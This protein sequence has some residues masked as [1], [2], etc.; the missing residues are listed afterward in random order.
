M[1]LKHPSIVLKSHCNVWFYCRFINVCVRV[2]DGLYRYVKRRGAVFV[3]IQNRMSEG[4]G[5]F[6]LVSHPDTAQPSYHMQ[7]GVQRSNKDKL[8]IKGLIKCKDTE[9]E[10]RTK[11]DF[12]IWNWIANII[13]YVFNGV[14]DGCFSMEWKKKC[15][16]S[17]TLPSSYS[18]VALINQ[19]LT[20]QVNAFNNSCILQPSS[21]L[22]SQH[23]LECCF[24]VRMGNGLIGS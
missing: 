21:N 5:E 12:Y 16:L 23:F 1:V 24:C 10:W 14:T 8:L 22:F 18:T 17:K 19:F 3:K 6:P 11:Q 4:A 9:S 15:K 7:K 13:L 20:M 2:R